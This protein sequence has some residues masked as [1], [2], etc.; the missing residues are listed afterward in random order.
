MKKL[1]IIIAD[2]LHIKLEMAS[3][4]AALPIAQFVQDLIIQS[5]VDL[6]AAPSPSDLLLAEGYRMMAKENAK[7]VKDALAAQLLAF[8][9][10]GEADYDSRPTR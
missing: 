5:A 2:E 3:K 7:T 1:E 6:D 8:D 10:S 9:N 4:R